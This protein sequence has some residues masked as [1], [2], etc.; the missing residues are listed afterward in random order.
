MGPMYSPSASVLRGTLPVGVVSDVGQYFPFEN[1]ERPLGAL[2]TCLATHLGWYSK[3]RKESQWEN[4]PAFTVCHGLSGVGKTTFVTDCFA[5]IVRT[6]MAGADAPHVEP[7]LSECIENNLC[8]HLSTASVRLLRVEQKNPAL[9][10]SMQVLYSF[11]NP[12]HKMHGYK[13]FF[14]LYVA[15]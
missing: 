12:H 14:N 6:G 4:S 7:I 10:L 15:P 1:R 2:I 5:H 9:F 3:E 13:E 8:F 11:L